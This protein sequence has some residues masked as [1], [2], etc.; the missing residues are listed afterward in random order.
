MPNIKSAEKRVKVIETKIEEWGKLWK[1][2][3]HII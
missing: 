3:N 1:E 2:E